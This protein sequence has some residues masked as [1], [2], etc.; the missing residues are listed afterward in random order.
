MQIPRRF[1]IA[2]SRHRILNPFTETKLRELG[3]ALDLRP[4]IS[5]LDLAAGKGE[6]LCR[7]AQV[8]GITGTGVDLHPPFV[9]A[10]RL[11]A[12]ELG[13]ADRVDFVEAD[14]AGWVSPEPVD[15]ASCLGASWIA[16]GLEGTIDLLGRSLKEVGI[17]LL[18]DCYW[19]EL[20]PTPEAVRGCQATSVQDHPT[21]E[22]FAGRVRDHGW[23]LVEMVLADEHSW[24]R[25]VAAQWLTLRR[26]VDAHPE[27]EL[28]PELRAELDS[29]PESYLRY[30]RR[31]LGWGVF[32]LIRR[33]APRVAVRSAPRSARSPHG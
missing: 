21:L 13:V 28:V 33:A 30:Q 2:E 6:L 9:H 10:A 26:F 1:T 24:D 19:R 15:I 17:A 16:G 22:G 7:W 31:Y 8:H 11:R 27:D 3:G 32:A 4:G 25:Y 18:G 14:A 23:D 5:M 20:P 29:A 12:Q